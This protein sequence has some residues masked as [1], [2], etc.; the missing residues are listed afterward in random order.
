[1]SMQTSN[2]S[3]LYLVVVAWLLTGCGSIPP[4]AITEHDVPATWSE[5]IPS[6]AQVWPNTEWWHGFASPE[7]DELIA[8]ARENNLD[9]A[10]AAARVLQ[11]EAS[12]RIAGAA[13]F[14]AIG[15]KATTQRQGASENGTSTSFGSFGISGLASYEVDFWGMARNNVR[16]AQAL[17][18]SAHYAQE[19]VALT[20]T[21]NVGVTYLE[22][23]GTR[24]RLAIAQQN[25][26]TARRFLVVVERMVAAGIA[27]P[28]DL[29]QQQALV[30]AQEGEIPAL[31]QS[32]R[33]LVYGLALLLGRPPEGFSVTAQSLDGIAIPAVAPGLPAEL[34]LR[35]PD[36][37]EAEANLVAAQANVD[38]ARAAFFP[39]ITLTAAGGIAS[40]AL[41]AVTDGLAVGEVVAGSGGTGSLYGVGASL[42]QTIFDG[43][44][45]QGRRELARAHEQELIAAYQSTA[46]NALYEVEAALVRLAGL[47]EQELL[48]VE[49]VDSSATALD[50]SERQ[51]RA[52][53][54]DLL[55]VLQTQQSLFGAQDELVQ[56]RLARIQVAV[57]LYKALGG[58]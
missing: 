37:A 31:Q 30:A 39:S 2:R 55:A 11:A 33:E 32:E 41:S 7:L 16:S 40:G 48:K 47:V 28:L 45:L 46:F 43:G 34:L 27:S 24:Q 14:P 58:G 9:L 52:G 36:L 20:V 54:I 5:P 6:N 18:R 42:W 26:E 25:L 17:L 10:A 57:L 23:L 21:A 35:R 49:Q 3:V 13:R 51:Y 15:I 8:R 56:I 44:A 12:A 38:A 53:L 1:M 50:I 4:V 22:V 19:V 29:A